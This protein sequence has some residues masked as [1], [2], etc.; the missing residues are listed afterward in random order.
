MEN[1]ILRPRVLRN[2]AISAGL[3]VTSKGRSSTFEIGMSSFLFTVSSEQTHR[4]DHWVFACVVHSESV[5]ESRLKEG[6]KTSVQEESRRSVIH[7][8]VN[9][10]P[11][12]Q[13]I[14]NCP[15]DAICRPADTSLIACA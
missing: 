7:N 6:T 13:A 15:R 14:I 2:F 1:T 9:V 3:V 8:A 4:Y 10:L 11:V 5:C 12:P